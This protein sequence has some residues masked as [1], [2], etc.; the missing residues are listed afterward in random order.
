MTNRKHNGAGALLANRGDAVP[1]DDYGHSA[2]LD[3]ERGP[4]T[5]PPTRLVSPARKQDSRPAEL[6]AHLKWIAG[7]WLH[8]AGNVGHWEQR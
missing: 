4:N 6:A 3:D 1:A 8:P 5:H 2:V 7:S